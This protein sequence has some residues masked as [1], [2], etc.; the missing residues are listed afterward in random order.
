MA[1][2]PTQA[3]GV[4]AESFAAAQTA[5]Y[6]G[7]SAQTADNK[8]LHTLLGGLVFKG[9]WAT[10]TAYTVGDVV[11]YQG[12]TFTALTAVL[13]TNTTP[14][15]VGAVWRSASNKRGPSQ[16]TDGTSPVPQFYR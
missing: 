9:P 10:A 6:F 5:G 11:S 7:W 3:A 12:D 16:V 8:S 14:P 15:A 13:S 1:T 4:P 2:I